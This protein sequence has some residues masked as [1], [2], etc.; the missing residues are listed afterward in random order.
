MPSHAFAHDE[1]PPG[2]LRYIK[3]V[4]VALRRYEHHILSA[5]IYG[6]RKRG[7]KSNGCLTIY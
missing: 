7:I 1:S 6:R 5:L 4:I 2:Y 3:S